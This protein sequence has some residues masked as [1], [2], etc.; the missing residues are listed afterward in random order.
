VWGLG[1]AIDQ[2][3][4]EKFRVAALALMARSMQIALPNR[5]TSQTAREAGSVKIARY[6]H[7]AVCRRIDGLPGKS[8]F[9]QLQFSVI[10]NSRITGQ[11]F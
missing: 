4:A 11:C 3:C 2:A 7:R 1:S 9:R 6:A 5:T 10:A 8:G